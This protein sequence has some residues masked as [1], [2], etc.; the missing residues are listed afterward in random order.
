MKNGYF[1]GTV[2]NETLSFDVPVFEG[3]NFLAFSVLQDPTGTYTRQRA[4]SYSRAKVTAGYR[5]FSYLYYDDVGLD[6]VFG[7]KFN[8][9]GLSPIKGFLGNMLEIRV[10]QYEELT[11]A[12]LDDQIDW[13]C[14]ASTNY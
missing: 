12:Q 8:N 5:T 11:L 10:Y 6:M 7:A 1:Y 3:W 13:D 14:S 4:V 2:Y 9:N